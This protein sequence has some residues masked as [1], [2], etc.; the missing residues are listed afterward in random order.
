MIGESGGIQRMNGVERKQLYEE[1]FNE[2]AASSSELKEKY[3][4]LIP[5]FKIAYEQLEPLSLASDYLREAGLAMEI[6]SFARFFT[7]LV[8]LSEAENIDKDAISKEIEK[9]YLG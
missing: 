7:K 6:V 1:E 8:K 9:W 4:N 2:W 3:G 5:A